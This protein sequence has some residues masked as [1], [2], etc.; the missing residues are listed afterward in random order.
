MIGKHDTSKLTRYISFIMGI[1]ELD[2][3]RKFLE[4]NLSIELLNFSDTLHPRL[5]VEY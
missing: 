4:R 2:P 5:L 1:K 3:K